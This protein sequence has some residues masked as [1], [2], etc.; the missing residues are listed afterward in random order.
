M[1]DEV[2]TEVGVQITIH[3]GHFRKVVKRVY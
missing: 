1:R 3:L 2:L